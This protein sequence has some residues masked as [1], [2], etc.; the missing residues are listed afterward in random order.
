MQMESLTVFENLAKKIEIDKKLSTDD[1]IRFT[2][3]LN[4][5]SCIA[6]V[7]LDSLTTDTSFTN[8]MFE[9][10][11]LHINPSEHA[12]RG[13]TWSEFEEFITNHN[14]F[15]ELCY[16]NKSN[17][18][19]N[20]LQ[21]E[22]ILK[23]LKIRS[24]KQSIKIIDD[25]NA[26]QEREIIFMSPKG[27]MVNFRIPPKNVASFL[28]HKHKNIQSV[29]T[30]PILLENIKF[31]EMQLD[32]G[33]DHNH[34]RVNLPHHFLPIIFTLNGG[35]NARVLIANDSKVGNLEDIF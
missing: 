11:L 6:D 8:S 10:S 32:C 28:K 31:K 9:F 20:N 35:L 19:M 7:V 22:I 30:I 15:V 16:E 13:V 14:Y 26:S 4:D 25:I 23:I 34:C 24:C 12:F 21:N 2:N 27:D 33:P 29:V 18:K 3:L 17:N 1:V 5:I